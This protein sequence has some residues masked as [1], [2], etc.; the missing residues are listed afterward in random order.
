MLAQRPY[1][2]ICRVCLRRCIRPPQCRRLTELTDQST[3][4]PDKNVA[5]ISQVDKEGPIRRVP[6]RELLAARRRGPEA[7][8]PEPLDKSA[9]GGQKIEEENVQQIHEVDPSSSSKNSEYQTQERSSERAS[10][11]AHISGTVQQKSSKHPPLKF[12]TTFF[13]PGTSLPSV[14]KEADLTSPEISKESP[15]SLQDN[16][17]SNIPGFLGSTQAQ[18]HEKPLPE[19]IQSRRSRALEK[20]HSPI[21]SAPATR[22]RHKPPPVTRKLAAT[23]TKAFV[24]PLARAYQVTQGVPDSKIHPGDPLFA[25]SGYNGSAVRE[26]VTQEAERR[27]SDNCERIWSEDI[28]MKPIQPPEFRPVPT[29]EHGLDRVLFK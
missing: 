28:E 21:P 23:Q 27:G 25:N 29:L 10:T 17:G 1:I 8:P 6:L 26:I 15:Q 14:S 18:D 13:Q 16:E 19:P 11:E 5:P 22:L 24:S 9:S 4:A 3:P 7:S 2:Y 20:S 12:P